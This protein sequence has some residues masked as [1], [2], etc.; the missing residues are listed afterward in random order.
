M[1]D[2]TGRPPVFGLVAGEASGDQLGA[3]LIQA[4]RESHP[5]ARF[6]GVGGARMEAV[7]MDCWRDAEELAVMGLFEV[8]GHLPRLLRLRRWLRGRF[9]E[10][11]PDIMIGIDAPDFNLGLERQLRA[12]GIPSL[13][14][15]SPTVW[16]WRQGRVRKIAR[17][18]DAV[19][20][21]FPFEPDFYAQHDVAAY[22]TGHPLAD[23]IENLPNMMGARDRL[24][25][26]ALDP[27]I[28][29]LPGSRAGEVSRLLK[30]LLGAAHILQRQHP[31]M[32]CVLPMAN[33]A[34]RT[35]LEQALISFPDLQILSVEGQA[36]VAMAAADIVVCASGTAALEAQL[37]NRPMV[38]V[39]RL[40]TPTYL[41]GKTFKLVKS[42]FFSLPNIL[43]DRQLVPELLQAEVTPES[44]A[45]EVKSWLDNP[46]RV[47]SLQQE[48]SSMNEELRRDAAR[49]A[50]AH[51]S[52]L[53][54]E[55]RDLSA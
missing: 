18:T 50:A 46:G 36:H 20:C 9:L 13:H 6:V 8:I 17:C 54:P 48:F 45:R 15:V 27:C 33:H 34:V 7:G 4:L 5:N 39:Y 3:A 25:L 38:V 53:L 42:R 2:H 29:L 47:Q 44:I 26:R 16:A 43:A 14:Y 52:G 37:V 30:P 41:L 49:T 19:L 11:R 10:E 55:T 1:G 12:G 40:S 22:Y 31:G 28:A 35:Q 51:I 21:L 24:G 32:Q 23:S